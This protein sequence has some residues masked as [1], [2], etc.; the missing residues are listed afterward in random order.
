MQKYNFTESEKKWQEYWQSTGVYKFDKNSTKPVFSIDTPPPTVNGKIHIG[1]IFSY[2]QAE[3]IA[4]YKRM[5]G[6]N[7]FY[8]LGFDDNGLPTERLVEKTNGRRAHEFTRE[9]FTKLCLNQTSELEERFRNLFISAG[10]SVDWDY[11]YSTI[12]PESQRTSQKSFL[13]IYKNG[14]VYYAE[15]PAI[16]CPECSTAIAQAELETL[17][18]P[19]SFNYMNF[20]LENSN[21]TIQIATV[22]IS[23]K[24]Q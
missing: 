4:R 13:D 21:E 24:M 2:T 8:P 17:E 23:A 9:E 19:S 10:F 5:S 3:I 11:S 20:K 15:A 6:Y 1:H 14:H 7:V 12:S 18:K 16:W 22:N